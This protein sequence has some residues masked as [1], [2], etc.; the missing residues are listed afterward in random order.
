VTDDDLCPMSDLPPDQCALPCHLGV[1][2]PE[3]A[4]PEVRRGVEPVGFR[5]PLT[6]AA[7]VQHE[8][9]DKRAR[10]RRPKLSLTACRYDEQAGDWVTREHVR[11]CRAHG[12]E[13]CK[14]CGKDHCALYGTCPNH[15]DAG[16]GLHT[17][18]SCIGEVRS[19]VSE[20]VELTTLVYLELE[21]AGV[22]S[23]AAVIS[24]PV[25][26]PDQLDAR[27]SFVTRRDDYRGWCDFPRLSLFDLD[28]AN[29]PAAVFAQWERD[30][31]REYEQAAR[32][33]DEPMW[34]LPHTVEADMLT[35]SAA[36]FNT[37]LDGRFPHDEPF[38]AFAKAI[39]RVRNHLEVVISDSRRP[40]MGAPCPTCAARL[41]D[42]DHRAPRLVKRHDEGD[43]TGA[44]DTWVCPDDPDHWWKEADYR[45]RVAGD[46]LAHAEQL[47][48]DL[49]QIQY[50]IP[51]G[52]IRRWA[53]V[54]RKFVDGEYVE[55][56]PLIRP[57]GR[58]PS[59]ARLY[60][61]KETLAVRDRQAGPLSQPRRHPHD[62]APDRR[63]PGD[64]TG[65]AGPCQPDVSP[66]G[67]CRAHPHETHGGTWGAG[68]RVGARYLHLWG[69]V[70]LP[71]VPVRRPNHR[72]P[73]PQPEP[74]AVR[75]GGPTGERC[76]TR[77]KTLCT[78]QDPAHRHV[79]EHMWTASSP[80]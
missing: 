51:A 2:L 17:C 58:M 11:D 21:H 8:P 48:A 72:R 73:P 70:R 75:V 52:T 24:G 10:T 31:R 44:S 1:S 42:T 4:E 49:I 12:C 57:V 7:S 69:R 45:L 78:I 33:D 16:A 60:D 53:N 71:A 64:A 27:R 28:D 34:P 13:G 50:G 26:D 20:I 19:L 22:N 55:S 56:P 15:V 59:G 29:H 14:P 68:R 3:G 36:Y 38:E 79:A 61:V 6:L 63:G 67:R 76:P 35:R 37:M 39:R 46:Y 5:Y 65:G 25:A 9:R 30:L 32:G 43:R 41:E 23:E 77:G 80:A 18:P 74:R 40:E 66:R 62:R 54:T 47:T